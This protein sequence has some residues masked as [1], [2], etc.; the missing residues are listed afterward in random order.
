MNLKLVFFLLFSIFFTQSNSILGMDENEARVHVW[1]PTGLGPYGNYGHV[2][3]E[4][5][6]YYMS[7]WPK[8]KGI[9]SDPQ[10][11]V[12]MLSFSADIEAEEKNCDKSY[13]LSTESLGSNFSIY[14]INREFQK[15]L[16]HNE[17]SWNEVKKNK[18][19]VVK[20]TKW[21][22]GGKAFKENFYYN[23]HSCITFVLNLLIQ[24]GGGFE[25]A[26]IPTRS[27]GGDSLIIDT[28]FHGDKTMTIGWF[29]SLLEDRL[30]RDENCIIS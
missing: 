23:P 5:T 15:F 2:S 19:I 8:N 9:L 25:R 4:T 12:L 16:E 11:G 17:I 7:F 13:T 24:G 3:L 18:N 27:G 26:L 30:N 28:L 29:I 14:N 6:K 20:K 10:P 21:N 1:K 22:Y